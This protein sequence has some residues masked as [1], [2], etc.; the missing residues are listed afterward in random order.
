M[1][2]STQKLKINGIELNVL[3]AGPEDGPPVLL[4]HGFPDDH[5]V[6]RYLL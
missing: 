5:T 3:L 4:L 2:T 6:W 1:N